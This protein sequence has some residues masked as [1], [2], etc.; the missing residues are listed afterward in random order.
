MTENKDYSLMKEN[1]MNPGARRLRQTYKITKDIPLVQKEF[2][3]Y[4]LERWEKEGM[5]QDVP[6][7][8]L[9]FFDE[10]GD[11]KMGGLGWTDP[12]YRP[13][14]EEKVVSETDDYEVVQGILGKTVKY[15]K[16]R[17]N[18]FMPQYLDHPA[19]DRYHWEKDCKWR[20]D[21][22][23]EQRRKDSKKHINKA[24]EASKEGK[25][26]VQGLAGAGMYLR[27]LMGVEEMLVSLYEDP[28]LIHEMMEVW[29]NLMDFCIAER[30]EY[31][32]LDELFIAEDI[33]YN[34]GPLIS[35]DMI[36]EFFYTYYKKYNENKKKRQRDPKRHLYIQ[37]DTDGDCRP[38]IPVYQEIGLEVMSPFE[39]AAGCDVVEIG[40][41]YTNLVLSGGID[42]R[43]LAK[44]KEDIDRYLDYVIPTMKKRG[45]YIPT[46]DHGV[47]EEVSY[48]NYM[49]YR[50]RMIEYN[51]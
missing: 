17:R 13:F 10:R 24:L 11:C 23:T 21:P 29:Y 42:K 48:E 30:Q 50:K 7:E 3:F 26:I 15:F 22:K 36:R 8:E 45:G 35:P 20:L 18:G 49:H 38:V 6:F 31:V 40:K 27:S 51:K 16:G 14:F 32:V 39:V 5:P 37:V 28:D 43:V 44:S 41:K 12:P 25:M 2:G 1:Q 34:H 33:C 4:T 46:C 47:P 19:K 9:F